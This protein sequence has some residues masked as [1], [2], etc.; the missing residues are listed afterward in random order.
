MVINPRREPRC[1]AVRGQPVRCRGCRALLAFE[2]AA[3][4]S[5]GAVVLEVAARLRCTACQAEREWHP[6]QAPV[7]WG[8]L[9]Y[10]RNR[11]AFGIKAGVA[12]WRVIFAEVRRREDGVWIPAV[13]GISLDPEPSRRQAEQAAWER[14]RQ[15]ALAGAVT[16]DG[17]EELLR[18][19]RAGSA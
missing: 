18:L 19:V 16:G 13:D 7:V 1:S 5:F 4:L 14:L 6:A 12:R 2:T 8:R 15:R 3:G 9:G 11:F 10:Y 17:A